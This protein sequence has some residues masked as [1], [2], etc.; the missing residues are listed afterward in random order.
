MKPAHF[1]ITRIPLLQFL[2]LCPILAQ[3]PIQNP[4]TQVSGTPNV[5]QSPGEIIP[6]IWK[7]E[8][9]SAVASIPL[10][11][12][13]HY[14]IQ[15]YKV[16][17][18]ALVRELTITTKSRS[19]IRI[20][21]LL[22]LGG[23]HQDAAERLDQR[24][25]AINGVL[26]NS[27]DQDDNIPIKSY[28]VTTHEKMVEYRVSKPEDIG[29]LYNSLEQSMVKFLARDLSGT[30]RPGVIETITIPKEE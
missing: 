16:D 8:I 27:R 1:T 7:A 28:P 20:Y 29:L 22:P 18:H 6:L 24:L 13:E 30:Q 9:G 19:M 23:I 14:G 26:D 2:T 11:S 15:D 3:S 4:V 17:S 25:Q 5:R 12:I 21:H 10:P